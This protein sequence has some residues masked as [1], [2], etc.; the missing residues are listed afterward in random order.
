MRSLH[1]VFYVTKE[2]DNPYIISRAV[3]AAAFI[4]YLTELTSG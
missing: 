3:E 1:G 4:D 2:G